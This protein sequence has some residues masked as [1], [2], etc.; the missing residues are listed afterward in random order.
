MMQEQRWS[1]IEQNLLCFPVERQASLNVGFHPGLLDQRVIIRVVII[2]MVLCRT[3]VEEHIQE[4]FRIGIVRT[5]TLLKQ[6]PI[7]PGVDLVM[8]TILVDPFHRDGHT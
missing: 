6:L 5:P 4:V 2:G 7:N 8:V 3:A 1:F